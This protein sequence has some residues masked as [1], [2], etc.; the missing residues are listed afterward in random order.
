MAVWLYRLIVLHAVDS[1]LESD[2]FACRILCS[3]ELKMLSF[4]FIYFAHLIS[5]QGFLSISYTALGMENYQ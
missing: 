4:P 1:A 2:I 5:A 3:D